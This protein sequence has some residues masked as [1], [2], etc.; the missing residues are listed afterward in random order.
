[1]AGIGA[2]TREM[3]GI[4]VRFSH[5]RKY[6]FLHDRYVSREV[7]RRFTSDG[8]GAETAIGSS[9]PSGDRSPKQLVQ[10]SVAARRIG[11][12]FA[13]VGN[14]VYHWG[15]AQEHGGYAWSIFAAS[16]QTSIR[17]TSILDRPAFFFGLFRH[18]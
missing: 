5:S 18:H 16:A 15:E 4:L 2:T 17:L 9:A 8:A 12:D 6:S 1:M 3:V 11:F 10:D 14:H 7:R 13:A